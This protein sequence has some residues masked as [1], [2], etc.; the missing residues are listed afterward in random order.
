MSNEAEIRKQMARLCASLFN[1][2]FSVGTA[3]NVSARLPDGC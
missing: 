3:G 2:G 1:R